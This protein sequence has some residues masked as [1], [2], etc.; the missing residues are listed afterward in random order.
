MTRG[1]FRNREPKHA[2]ISCI[3]LQPNA[4]SNSATTKHMKRRLITLTTAAALAIGAAVTLNAH[5][6]GEGGDRGSHGGHRKMMKMGMALEHL[7]KELELTET[8]KAQVQPIVD[9]TTPQIRQ[10]H[11]EAME[12]SKA[13]M[14]QAA[15]QIRPLLTAEQQQK[16]DALRAAHAK[17]REARREMREAK[18]Q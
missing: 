12:K 14:E 6:H 7:T 8:Q 2:V 1:L 16:F 5:P 13:V 10:I 17:M 15:A 11:Q 4:H 3:A 9:Q 18:R